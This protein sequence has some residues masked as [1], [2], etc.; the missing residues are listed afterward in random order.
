MC[1]QEEP[2]I[3]ARQQ[4]ASRLL[5]PQHSVSCSPAA[6]CLAS[7]DVLH[8]S[9]ALLCPHTSSC[10][11]PH[12]V[13]CCAVLCCAIQ[14]ARGRDLGRPSHPR[15]VKTPKPA[16]ASRKAFRRAYRNRAAATE[17]LPVTL[18][19]AQAV[20]A[21]TPSTAQLASGNTETTTRQTWN[22]IVK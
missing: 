6:D 17:M 2:P 9:A 10:T 3:S 21:C 19:Q 7:T 1:L 18:L 11:L 20:E 13:A 8:A 22:P 4:Q 12:P 15:R 5:H 16:R 14:V